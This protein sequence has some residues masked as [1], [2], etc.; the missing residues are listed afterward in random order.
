MFTPVIWYFGQCRLPV[1]RIINK[2]NAAICSYH[3]TYAFQSKS[4]LYSCLNVRELFA[5]NR[6]NIWSLRVFLIIYLR[7]FKWKSN[8]RSFTRYWRMGETKMSTMSL[9]SQKVSLIYNFHWEKKIQVS[10][11]WKLLQVQDKILAP[12]TI[13]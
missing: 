7:V 8:N 6:R 1:F 10:I 2:S 11:E 3:V 9:L 13:M 12:C 4:T 5:R